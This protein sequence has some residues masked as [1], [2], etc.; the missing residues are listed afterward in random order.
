MELILERE[1]AHQQKAVD[2][3]VSAFEGV[4]ITK[5]LLAYENPTFDNKDLRLIHNIME[6]QNNIRG[7]YRG[8]RDEGEYLNLDVKMETGT[9]KTYVYT[10]TI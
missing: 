8:R 5:P 4:G 7:D 9:G 10:Q 3:L 2:T 1:L 6:I